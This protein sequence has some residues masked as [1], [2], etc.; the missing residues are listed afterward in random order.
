MKIAPKLKELREKEGKIYA[1]LKYFRGLPSL[2][3]VEDRYKKMLKK[4]YKPFKTD[5][6][7]KTKTSQYTLAFRK[8]YPNA[9]TLPEISKATKIPLSNLQE[10]YNKGLA[11]WRTGHRPGASPQAWAYA[12]V[13]SYA[14]KGKTYY[15]ADRYLH[16]R[17]L[18]K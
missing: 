18:K 3:A 15:T 1:P 14:M 4:N 5:K 7:M 13:H 2:K 6:N 10:V 11:A 8:K 12:R 16:E 9:V 17:R